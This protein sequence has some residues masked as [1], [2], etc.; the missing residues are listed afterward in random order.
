MRIFTVLIL[1]LVLD[2]CNKKKTIQEE[3]SQ[4]PS[5]PNTN[6]DDYGHG[7]TVDYVTVVGN[8][9]TIFQQRPK[10]EAE[11]NKAVAEADPNISFAVGPYCPNSINGGHKI[12]GCKQDTPGVIWWYY[13]NDDEKYTAEYVQKNYCLDGTEFIL[14]HQMLD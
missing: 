14:P 2:G 10:A 9:C 5:R 4:N 1:F 12:G 8:V 6:L 3:S 11:Q 13:S 7:D